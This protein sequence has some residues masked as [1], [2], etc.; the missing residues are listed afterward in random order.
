MCITYLLILLTSCSLFGTKLKTILQ[1]MINNKS[2]EGGRKDGGGREDG[3][4][5]HLPGHFVP[6]EI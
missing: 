2:R 3:T 6:T 4:Y 5:A 1:Y